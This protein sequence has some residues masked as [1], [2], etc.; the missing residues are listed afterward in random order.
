MFDMVENSILM[1][2]LSSRFGVTGNAEKWFSSYLQDLKF[3]VEINNTL[4]KEIT[5]NHSVTQ[6]SILGPTL[7]SCYSSTLGN[8]VKNKSASLWGICW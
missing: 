3:A 4:P 2:V 5:I 7:F 1:N 8:V 6:G